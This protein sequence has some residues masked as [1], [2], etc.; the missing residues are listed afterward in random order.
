M[1]LIRQIRVAA[2][3]V[4][5]ESPGRVRATIPAAQKI[6]N[7]AFGMSD[8]E[9]NCFAIGELLVKAGVENLSGGSVQAE[10]YDKNGVLKKK[11]HHDFGNSVA[12]VK[13]VSDP[14]A[15][16]ASNLEPDA[17]D[18]MSFRLD[19]S[20]YA[21]WTVK[22][23]IAGNMVGATPRISA[24][25]T[26]LGQLE[27]CS[28]SKKLRSDVISPFNRSSHQASVVLDGNI[29]YIVRGSC[30]DVNSTL[31]NYLPQNAQPGYSLTDDV[32]SPDCLGTP[33]ICASG[34]AR[35]DVF[36][37][38]FKFRFTNPTDGLKFLNSSI[39]ENNPQGVVMLRADNS[40]SANQ[41]VIDQASGGI[42]SVRYKKSMAMQTLVDALN[43]WA[44]INLPSKVAT[45]DEGYL[46]GE[47]CDE[48]LTHTFTYPGFV[49]VSE[50]LSDTTN[51][52][53]VIGVSNYGCQNPPVPDACGGGGGGPGDG[54][55]H[56]DT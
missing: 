47:N 22:I 10:L 32:A 23:K 54:G 37:V 36:G 49:I 43:A 34:S 35:G 7:W 20:Q 24:K 42:F 2:A 39:L 26:S 14:R 48:Q 18:H 5:I 44:A 11:I 21:T 25:T 40:L 50:E 4:V 52:T 12:S 41:V 51:E 38:D 31:D 8:S 19:P 27:D 30:V 55:G 9:S 17:Q 13:L 1:A 45:A 3:D 29:T 53:P 33:I 46:G 15:G 28:G 6:K 16:G 56:G